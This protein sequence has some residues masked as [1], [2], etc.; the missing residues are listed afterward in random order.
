MTFEASADEM[1]ARKIL[2][3]SVASG[4]SKNE[5]ETGISFFGDATRFQITTYKPAIV[6]KLLLHSYAEIEWVYACREDEQNETL[7][8]LA[9]LVEHADHPNIGGVRAYLPTGALSIKGKPRKSNS[10]SRIVNTPEKADRA[11]EVFSNE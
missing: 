3:E 10:L 1:R 4:L 11:R 5:Q 9:G 8:D 2:A 7:E 6:R